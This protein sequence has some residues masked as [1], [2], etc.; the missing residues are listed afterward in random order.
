MDGKI[1]DPKDLSNPISYVPQFGTLNGELTARET[2]TNMALLKRNMP[3]QKIQE[4]VSDLLEKMGLSH[5]CDGIIGTVIFRG[6]SGGQKKR[7]EIAA[8]LIASPSILI[9]DEPTSGLDSSIAFEVVQSIREMAQQSNGMLSVILSIHQPNSSILSLFDH[10]L[11]LERGATIFFG[12][13]PQSL[14]YFARNGHPC[15]PSVTSTDYF[16]QISD[17]NFSFA[18]DADFHF[19]F[20]QSPENAALV[21]AVDTLKKLCEDPKRTLL[22]EQSSNAYQIMHV[23]FYK[24]FY[25]L[26]YRDFT[27]AY[28]DPTLYYFQVVLLI[29]FGFFVGSVFWD[30]P[31]D[32]NGQFNL[33]TSGLLWLTLMFCWIHAFKVFYISACDKRTVHEIS[34]N[35]YSPLTVVLSDTLT[36]ATMACAFFPVPAI[37]YFMMGYPS[38]GFGFLILCCWMTSLAAEAMMSFITKFSHSPT[39]SMV[40]AQIALVNLEVFGGGVFLPWNECPDWWIWLQESCVFTQGSRA[41]IME[42]LLYLEFD[43]KLDGSGVCRDPASNNIYQCDRFFG[44]NTMCKVK[45]REI[46]YVTQGIGHD[47]SYWYYFGYLC[48][49]FLVFKFAIL[50][51]TFYP[52][53]RIHYFLTHKLIGAKYS[54]DLA[55]LKEASRISETGKTAAGQGGEYKKVETTEHVNAH[56]IKD[57][58]HVV[59]PALQKQA[60]AGKE[61]SFHGA[62]HTSLTWENMN[63]ILAKNNSY[64]CDNVSGYVTSGRVLALMGPSGAGK[65]T[66]LN[67]LA[68]RATYAVIEGSVRFSGRELTPSDLTYVPQFDEVNA[69]MTVYEHMVFVGELTCVDKAEMLKRADDLLEVLGLTEK[70]DVQI[71]DL[72]G[73]EVK[74][75]SVG[76]GMISNPHVLFLDE[77]TTGLDSTAAF[78][79]VSY[80]VTVAKATNVAVIMTIH[81]PSALVFEML[82]D[83]LLLEGGKVVY[84]GSISGA[85]AYFESIGYKNP[86]KLN[87][88]DYFLE[89]VMNPP[90]TGGTWPEIFNKS[91]YRNTFIKACENAR[92]AKANKAVAAQPGFMVRNLVMLKYFLRYFLREPGFFIHRIYALIVTAV[93]AGTLYLQLQPNTGQI[94]SYIGA[95]FFT[96]LAVMLTAVS[97]TALFAKDRR[98][99]VDRI[100]NGFFTPGLYVSNQFIASSF[101]NWFAAFVFVCIFHW[102]T[103]VAGNNGEAFVFNIFISWGHLLIMEAALMVFVEILKNE[104]LST[105]TG[106][107]FIGTNMLFCG[108]FRPVTDIPIAVRWMCY[109]FPLKWSLDGFMWQIFS[110]QTFLVDKTD[111]NMYIDGEDIL[112]QNFD[113]RDVP[114]WGYFG[115]LIGYVFLFRGCQFFLLSVQTDSMK[116]PWPFSRPKVINKGASV[117]KKICEEPTPKT[118]QHISPMELAA[119]N[120]SAV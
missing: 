46:L 71:E 40:F 109:L 103:K 88:A 98:E 94:N 56:E 17:S 6:L 57:K 64:L 42:V 112:D 77:P 35:S 9:L 33:I 97:S 48:A 93:F 102:T 37:A 45:G 30:L 4:D 72:S 87:P 14:E 43:C 27:L 11:L 53:D 89:L 99:A 39:V 95:V 44:G 70:K 76:I 119:A 59:S 80:L 110:H 66:L 3:L 2:T 41:M 120:E 16:L 32:V 115:A 86:E 92:N 60:N 23:P 12:S 73:G 85:D 22:K 50:L 75:I 18:K 83:L 51:L 113:L 105:T 10:I 111:P 21:G 15:P 47:D 68:G 104:F 31:R 54:N 58:Y 117:E 29:M 8:E 90:S 20:E 107:I 84:G 61:M 116:L 74:R 1:V 38:E 19:V 69:V 49:I 34:N 62:E 24:K 79:I 108:F 65:T 63:V 114:S 100:S 78:S 101:Y 106:M 67:A 91:S 26:L 25:T 52:W 7:A 36:T 28:R 118:V 5:V 82:D 55:E 81:Q 13:V 96:A